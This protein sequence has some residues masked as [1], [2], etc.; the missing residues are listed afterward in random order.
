MAALLSRETGTVH[1]PCAAEAS[2]EAHTSAYGSMSQS[3]RQICLVAD[4]MVHLVW[5][6]HELSNELESSYQS[7][8]NSQ[9]S[10]AA[11]VHGVQP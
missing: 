4:R 10:L 11:G 7:T 9:L 2:P 8:F 5:S 3:T 1:N 6:L